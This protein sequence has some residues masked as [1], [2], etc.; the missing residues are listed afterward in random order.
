M[1]QSDIRVTFFQECEELVEALNDGLDEIDEA[2]EDGQA[3][4]ETVN[5]VFRAVHS[6]KGGAGAF[7]LETLVRFAHHFE[8]TLDAV[9]SGKVAP[10]PAL[11]LLFHRAADHLSDLLNAARDG[12]DPGAES[13]AELISLLA[14]VNGGDEEEFNDGDAEDFGFVPMA[15]SFDED[16][17]EEGA[18]CFEISFSPTRAL[19]ANGHDPSVLF[20]VL[21]DL[22]PVSVTLDRS[23]L[24]PFDALDWQQPYLDWTLSLTSDE[25][26]HQI[27]EVFEFVEGLCSL[28]IHAKG[29]GFVP[30]SPMEP[31]PLAEV[32]SPRIQPT[33]PPPK[34]RSAET[35]ESSDKKAS[36][37]RA[38]VRVELDRVDRLIN[39]VGELVINQAMLSQCVQDAGMPARSAVRSG[40]DD[41]KSLAREIQES[42]MAI[43]AQ[44]IK[45]L[46]QRMSRIAREASDIAGKQV[47]LLT[48]G[49]TTEVDKTVIERLAD[50]L[51][52]MI[53]NAVDHGI[54]AA[55]VRRAAGKPE[56]GSITLSAAHRSGRVLIE[57]IDDGGGINRP[58]VKQIAASKG[59]IPPDAELSD[60]EIDMLLFLPGFS[61]STVVSD[62]SGRGVGMDVVKSAIQAL[63]GRVAIASTPGQGTTFSISLP[64]TLAVLDG[65]V[66]DVAGQTMV[67]PI[68]AIVETLRPM[69]EDVHFLGSGAQVVTIRGAFVPIIDLGAAFGHR[70]PVQ[71]FSERVLMLVENEQQKQCAL[72][73]DAI[74]DQRQVVIKGMENG[75]GR[76][77]GIAA[78]TILG[79]GR[80][81][82]IIDPDEA[83]GSVSAGIGDM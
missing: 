26:E 80:I 24:P 71:D 82:L 10:D 5:A 11:L 50:P 63:G 67:V 6:I 72:V 57:V 22:G 69:P 33:A 45:P 20:R 76:I 21:A 18:R 78:A 31:E 60:A 81:A 13:G 35:E 9:R 37:P 1:E 7:K 28:E 48:E 66:V 4:P 39:V 30:P 23:R 27:D 75:Y 79:D 70:P 58:K 14:A 15:L 32:P 44:A 34:P 55:E 51:T 65:M 36:A 54:E 47:R 43:R 40:L 19:Y 59:L 56:T 29:A 74:Y 42:V 61:T 77:P 62:L 3:E 49:E 17:P 2:L 16:P 73:V 41:F 38:T 64:L 83:V 52:H 8:T 68:T 25:P 12:S 53:R 46:F